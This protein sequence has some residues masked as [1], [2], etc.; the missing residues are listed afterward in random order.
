MSNVEWSV[1]EQGGGWEEEETTRRQG[2]VDRRG[3]TAQTAQGHVVPAA[4]VCSALLAFRLRKLT[5]FFLL[6]KFC[7]GSSA[8]EKRCCKCTPTCCGGRGS[9]REE[10]SVWTRLGLPTTEHRGHGRCSQSGGVK[11][12]FLRRWR[13]IYNSRRV[14]A[15]QKTRCAGNRCPDN[16]MLLCVST[17]HLYRLHPVWPI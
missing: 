12:T 1:G 8:A 14:A 4:R 7:C 11:P 17:T 9:G 15:R 2:R 6:R 13:R 5:C 3:K 16:P 10:K